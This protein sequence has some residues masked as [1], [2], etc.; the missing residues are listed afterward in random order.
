MASGWK[1]AA[2]ESC[3]CKGGY[4][5]RY[6]A[7]NRNSKHVYDS[8]YLNSYAS[9]LT[10]LSGADATLSQYKTWHS[11]RDLA[12]PLAD[13]SENGDWAFGEKDEVYK[14]GEDRKSTGVLA[15]GK[16]RVIS[17]RNDTGLEKRDDL[18]TYILQGDIV[19]ASNQTGGVLL[20]TNAEATVDTEGRPARLSYT[21]TAANN[22]TTRLTKRNDWSQIN[23]Q[24]WAAD[25]SR[26]ADPYWQDF[27][28]NYVGIINALDNGS[29]RGGCFSVI[30]D[31]AFWA[32]VKIWTVITL[33]LWDL[34]AEEAMFDI[35]GENAWDIE[36]NPKYPLRSIRPTL[37]AADTEISHSG[38]ELERMGSPNRDPLT[39][40][41]RDDPPQT[42]QMSTIN[43]NP[44]ATET[45]Y[46]DCVTPEEML[47]ELIKLLQEFKENGVSPA[48][49]A[50]NPQ[51][52]CIVAHFEEEQ[53]EKI[54][55]LG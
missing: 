44:E 9:S 12:S 30:D 24:F 31:A 35:L 23:F 52:V 28:D 55:G 26:N 47:P 10:G 38:S 54:F 11:V 37:P 33:V 41:D 1:R 2:C 4:D 39:A 40:P 32:T 16:W 46:A 36:N 17:H 25:G 20:L 53:W 21:V 7:P 8:G 29:T 34:N 18:T 6:K 51:G 27:Y 13:W 45:Q 14:R 19:L 43:F 5:G 15:K 42:V 50:Y 22:D 49:I 48:S 3:I